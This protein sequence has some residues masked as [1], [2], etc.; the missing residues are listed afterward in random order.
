MKYLKW[1]WTGSG[2]FFT[3]Y[4]IIG[5]FENGFDDLMLATWIA[6]VCSGAGLFYKKKI[7]PIKQPI[8]QRRYSPS[9]G[10]FLYSYN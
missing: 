5:Y 10:Y 1:F 3:L 7:K 4:T 6:L 9:D 8:P 2:V